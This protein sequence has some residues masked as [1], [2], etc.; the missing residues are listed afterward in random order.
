ME[1]VAG[2]VSQRGTRGVHRSSDGPAKDT[3]LMISH[4][5]RMLMTVMN[6]T[7]AGSGNIDIEISRYLYASRS[8]HRDR[9]SVD[10]VETPYRGLVSRKSLQGACHY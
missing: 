8:A 6:V 9:F 3:A 2:Q 4:A 7:G 10:D 1:R 5:Y